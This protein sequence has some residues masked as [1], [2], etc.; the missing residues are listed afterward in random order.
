MKEINLVTREVYSDDEDDDDSDNEEVAAIAMASSSSPSTSLFDSPN[1]NVTNQDYK[2]LMAKATEVTPSSKLIT[3]LPNVDDD[4]SLEIKRELVDLDTFVT[5]LQGEA[6]ERFKALMDECKEAQDLIEQQYDTIEMLQQNERDAANEIGGLT[7]ALEERYTPSEE[8]HNMIISKLT[9]E[10]DHALAKVKVLTQEKVEFGVVHARLLKSRDQLQIQLTSLQSKS[11]LV[12]T[13]D[14]PSSSTSCCDHTNL[15]E[16]NN[17]LKG[18]L[19]ERIQ[20]G[21]EGL[22][23]V[24]NPKK[25]SKKKN[26][27]KGKKVAQVNEAGTSHNNFAGK[28]NPSYVLMKSYDG[29]VYAKYVGTSYGDDYH[30]SIWVPKTLVANKRG[31]IE[32]WVPKSKN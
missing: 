29:S 23:Y 5:N 11:S 31:P 28:Y 20:K 25:K 3:H 14:L 13:M 18:Q 17:K 12:Q 32:K 1:E 16:E 19:V 9:K 2:C 4:D 30:W 8:E 6:K 7:Q 15:V 21:K 26:N 22:G 10:R 24:S 27:K